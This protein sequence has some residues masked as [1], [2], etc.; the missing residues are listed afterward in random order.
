MGYGISGAAFRFKA[1]VNHGA[2]LKE[3][4]ETKGLAPPVDDYFNQQ[5]N[6][7]GFFVNCQASFE[8]LFF[9]LHAIGAHFDRESFDLSNQALRGVHPVSVTEKYEA[10][11]SAAP[12][13]R[14]L[15]AFVESEEFGRLKN[16]RNVLLHRAV[17]P[18][19]IAISP[20]Q[21][22]RRYWQIEKVGMDESDEEISERTFDKWTE[23]SAQTMNKLWSALADFP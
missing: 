16:I 18:S 7:F 15:R 10:T 6:L 2:V 19:L 22:T 5:Q 9:A 23:W 11:W 21:D 13:T 8:S 20:G 17:P 4:I 1:M 14:E 12:L 3:L